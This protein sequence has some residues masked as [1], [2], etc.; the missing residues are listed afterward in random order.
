M[1]R[2]KASVRESIAVLQ[3]LEVSHQG[4]AQEVR[5]RMLRMLKENPSYTLS[6]VSELINCSERSVQRW[7][8]VYNKEGIEAVL[9]IQKRGRKQGIQVSE[10]IL[11]ALRDK[12]RLD[13]FEELKDA[14]QWLRDTHG[15]E[16][17][18]SSVWKLLKAERAQTGRWTT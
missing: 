16:Y 13:G 10:S 3:N 12:L 18:R 15:I 17:S 5:V 7:W 11:N 6:Q 2:S 4:K 9:N 14:Q 8:E 1:P